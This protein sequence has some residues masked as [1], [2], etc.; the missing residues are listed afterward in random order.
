MILAI[1][2]LN[3]KSINDTINME[4]I[5]EFVQYKYPISPGTDKNGR[6][7]YD[8]VMSRVDTKWEMGELDDMKYKSCSKSRQSSP[9]KRQ[10][11]G[12]INFQDF[13]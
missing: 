10:M 9:R 13:G 7:I 1:K 11:V 6:N 5:R 4:E 3:D 2:E 12:S 8:E